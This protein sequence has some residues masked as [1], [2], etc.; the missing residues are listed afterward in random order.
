MMESANPSRE[1]LPKPQRRASFSP[2]RAIR[3]LS[4]SSHS[5]SSHSI[6]SQP[7]QSP[8][9]PS[10]DVPKDG[11]QRRTWRKSMPPGALRVENLIRKDSKSS[12]ECSTRRDSTSTRLTTPSMTSRRTSFHDDN[13]LVIKSGHLH[14]ESSI[15]K[16][17]KEYLVLTPSA[18]F[19]FKSY[20]IAKQQFPMINAPEH[21]GGLEFRTESHSSLRSLASLASSVEIS[22]P[23]EKVV[24]VF[25]DDATG[26]SSGIEIWWKSSDATQSFVSLGLDFGLPDERDD[27]LQKT[28]QAVG[29]REGEIGG[30]RVPP[31]IEFDFTLT[32][33]T[34]H[35]HMRPTPIEIYPVIPRSPYTGL[36]GEHKK[37]WRESSSF[38]LAFSKYSL[39]L[40]QFS[41]S[42]NGQKLNPTLTHFG[43]VNFSRIRASANDER[44]TLIFR[45]PLE[46]PRQIQLSSR[47]HRAILSNLFRADMYLKPAWP[48]WTREAFHIHDESQK[49]PLPNG[50]DY[51][52]FRTTL[53]AFIEA[54]H[55]PPVEWE[56]KWKGVR[57]PPQFCLLKPKH[58]SRYSCHQLLA[59][60][61]ALRFNEFFHGISFRDID[62]SSLVNKFDNTQRLESTIWLSRTGKRSLTYSEVNMV[63]SGS[64]LF[65]ELV[66]ILLGSESIKHIDMANVLRKVRTLPS[67]HNESSSSTP[68]GICE[69]MPPITML[70]KS[71]Q[72][73]CNS[74]TLNGNAMGEPD[75]LE[76]Y[77]V[78]QNRSNFL[79]VFEISRCNLDE[80]LLVYVFEG[81]HE[82]RLS[83]EELDTS[84]N[85]GRIEASRVA[86]TLCE[87]SRLKRLNLAY[88][89]RG[90]L[91]G[92]LFKPWGSSESPQ[93]WRLEELDLSGWQLNYDTLEVLMEYL[94]LD[95]SRGLRRLSLNNCSLTGELAA[96]IFRRIGSGRDLRLSLNG[97][98]LEAESTD[99]MDL[100]HMNEAP[101]KLHLDMI[102]FQHESNF[103]KL[104]TALAYNKTI[105]FLSMAGTGPPGRVTL[106]TSELL[107]KFFRTNDTLKFL[108]LS[109][110]SGKLEDGELGWGL[111][112]ALGGLA[113][114]ASLRQLRLRNHD[115]GAAEDLSKLCRLLAVNKGLAMVDIRNNNFDHQQFGKLVHALSYNHQIISFPLSET[116]RDYAINKEKR[117]IQESQKRTV[118]KKH[119]KLSKSADKHLDGLLT[120]LRKYWDSETARVRE[121]LASNRDNV[122]NQFVEL[123]SEYLEAWDDGELPRWLT[124]KPTPRQLEKGKRR[125]SEPI[126]MIPMGDL[127]LRAPLSPF[128]QIEPGVPSGRRASYP[129]PDVIEEET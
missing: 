94:T 72:T 127:S 114:N 59:V 44:F 117:L 119:D 63:E 109:G 73:R 68:P 69:I 85:P 93:A 118:L 35:R 20:A 55:C 47:C 120:W 103:N 31:E 71:L 25:K 4:I 19:K 6:G 66:S 112:D 33:R 36:S 60:F 67:S 41:R 15:L 17:K 96:G 5:I 65:Q 105:V 45:L 61:R 3:S 91:E 74:I 78:L 102:Q 129:P 46:Q 80:A 97:N 34:K 49:L 123:D 10:C 113:Y 39:F 7:S 27:W 83:L 37:N 88:T 13:S 115:M 40:A 82:Q 38:Y 24:S 26:S 111:S 104:L 116:D 16:S 75:T 54:Y 126:R 56:V 52:G 122:A 99:W 89:I 57:Y 30:E 29:V 86:H 90:D 43:L 32:L 107:S 22:V 21:A 2:M 51:G 106:K 28:R 14:P 42:P 101:T 8:I 77:R 125:A 53:E 108:D 84:Y 100:I 12:N 121:I 11:P 87:A 110:Y 58:Q 70:W 1:P 23:L 92:P 81:L 98:P 9:S 95:E 50:E 64:V 124:P 62:F 48:L 128:F 76:L 79:K 18:L